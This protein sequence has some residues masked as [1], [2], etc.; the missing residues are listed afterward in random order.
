MDHDRFDSIVRALFA[1]SRQSRRAALATLLG[2][3]LL[4]PEAGVDARRKGRDRRRVAAAA[5]CYP[6]TRCNPGPGRNTSGCDF[7]ASTL[8]RNR[9]ARGA[10]LSN[11]NF[12]GANLSGADLRSAN[13]S[14]GCFVGADL[15][16]AK[17][18]GSVN[19][20]KAVFCHTTM[21]DGSTDNS[22]CN[23]P[24]SCCPT[25]VPATCASLG[26]SCGTAP[27]G[28]GGTLRCGSCGT[29]ETPT[30]NN[31]VCARCDA[32]CAPLCG[33]FNLADGNTRCGSTLGSSCALPCTS[34]ADCP[35][36]RPFCVASITLRS[37][38]ETTTLATICGQPGLVGA[39]AEVPGC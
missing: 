5:A 11:C 27:D 34:N 36:A 28:C 3:A 4:R 9:N 26:I 22:G 30:C 15:T 8:F 16:G 21:P 13:L 38:N 14:G 2:A 12:T 37:L 31:G 7:S 6:A 23:S 35:A 24:T 39:C 19:L 25:C 17:V 20:S 33:C 1:G 10:N 18:G 29:G 32:T